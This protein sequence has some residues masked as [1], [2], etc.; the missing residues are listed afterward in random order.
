[1]YQIGQSKRLEM[2]SLCWNTKS[3]MSESAKLE[4]FFENNWTFQSV[5]TEKSFWMKVI[6]PFLILWME[7]DVPLSPSKIRKIQNF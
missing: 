1:M 4:G 2:D 7:V 5:K 6:G 3:E